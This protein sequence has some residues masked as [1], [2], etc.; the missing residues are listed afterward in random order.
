MLRA[1]FWENFDPR[2]SYVPFLIYV[3]NKLERPACDKDPKQKE[4]CLKVSVLTQDKFV[5]FFIFLLV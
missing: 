5:I 1:R 3:N 2:G 4:C